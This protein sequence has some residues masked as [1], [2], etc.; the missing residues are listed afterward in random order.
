MRPR[1][2][3]VPIT[4]AAALLVGCTS[5]GPA[6]MPTTTTPSDNGVAALAPEEILTRAQSALATA[7][8]Y[9]MKGEISNEG[10][11]TKI[12][13][14]NGG[15]NVKGSIDLN[16]QALELL[17]IDQDLYMKAADAFW[18][19]FI[20]ADQQGVLT[21][22]SGKYVKVDATNESFSAFTEAFDA[23]EILKAEG[24]VTKSTP[25]TIHGTPA[26]GLVSSDRDAT[27]YIAMTG[28]PYPLRIEGKPSQGSVDF[29]DFGKSIEFTPPAASEVVDLKA[30]TGG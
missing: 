22:L 14:Q 20:P 15:T 8:S 7:T 27:L 26:I 21:L 12:D 1:L 18:K 25:T 19:Q 2:V 10:Q 17:R 28:E 16:G 24:S 4:M 3:L 30:I 23:S 9:R 5:P 6:P 29:T 13:L 11:T